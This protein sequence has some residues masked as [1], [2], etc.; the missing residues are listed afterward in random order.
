MHFLEIFV[1]QIVK[2]MLGKIALE[3]YSLAEACNPNF[4]LQSPC[5][6]AYQVEKYL[7]EL[8]AVAKKQN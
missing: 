6:L 5:S 7:V 8:V 1:E 2:C 4:Y 3:P